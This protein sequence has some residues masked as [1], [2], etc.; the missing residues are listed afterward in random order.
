M[1]NQPS[2]LLGRGA[3]AI[4]VAMI[5]AEAGFLI[6]LYQCADTDRFDFVTGDDAGR[7]M[8]RV[9]RD[10]QTI[11]A[12]DESA[13][14]RFA[15][16][17]AQWALMTLRSLPIGM[18]ID[19]WIAVEM[20]EL[21]ELQRTGIALQ[22]QRTQV[23]AQVDAGAELVSIMYTAFKQI[24]PKMDSGIDLQ[25]EYDVALAMRGAR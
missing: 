20:P 4:R 13:L 7:R 9:V 14:A 11:S 21:K 15:D 16:F 10:A 8:E 19:R 18:H 2:W 17:T 25:R 23:H 3:P 5:P 6:R 24:D 1:A 12:E 22:Q